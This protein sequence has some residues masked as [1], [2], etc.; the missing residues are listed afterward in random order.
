MLHLMCVTQVVS[1]CVRVCVCEFVSHLTNPLEL[2]MTNWFLS[3]RS[4][5]LNVI[6]YVKSTSLV[7]VDFFSLHIEKDLS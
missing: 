5:H 7:S 4:G 1:E 6:W 2:T 3:A